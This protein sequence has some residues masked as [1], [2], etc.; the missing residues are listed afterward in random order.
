M[1]E[2]L[3]DKSISSN[4]SMIGP[5]AALLAAIITAFANLPSTLQ[6]IMVLLIA[7]IAVVSVYVV[8]GQQLRRFFKKTTMATKHHFL[9]KKYFSEFDSFVDRLEELL[10]DNRSDNIPYVFIHLQNMPP[11]FNYPRSLI[12]DLAKL[13]VVFK[14]GMKKVHKR[15]FRFLIKWFELILRVYNSQ[16]VLQPF[17]QIRN[18]YND[19]L[20]EHHREAYE[21]N[22][23][24]YVSFLQN[25]IKFAKDINK[26]WGEEVAQY[27][28]DKPGKLSKA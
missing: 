21:K 19:K 3:K 7:V 13:L 17:Q 8:F 4:V 15:N 9:I 20:T 18:L 5:L 2:K 22:R 23:E 11:E 26:D 1:D 25:Y 28:F 27:Y 10:N 16:L 14:E 24:D 6:Y 12:Y